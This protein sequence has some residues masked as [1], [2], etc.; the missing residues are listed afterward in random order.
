[1]TLEIPA[2]IN[3]IFSKIQFQKIKDV[4]LSPHEREITLRVTAG[5]R[6]VA[7][8]DFT[9][10]DGQNQVQVTAR[11]GL[12]T[13]HLLGPSVKFDELKLAIKYAYYDA[14]DE[15]KVVADLWASGGQTN[16]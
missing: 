13:F 3:Q 5:E 14:R 10:W 6:P 16:L 7:L 12:A 2:R 1:M 11:D 9:F 8:L 15:F 4:L